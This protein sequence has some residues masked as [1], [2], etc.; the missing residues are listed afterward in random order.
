LN[1][2]LISPLGWF[3]PEHHQKAVDK[4]LL[5]QPADF[6]DGRR[7][8][9]VCAECGDLGCGALS[10]IVEKDGNRIVWRDFLYQNDYDPDI[11]YG[12]GDDYSNLGPFSFDVDQYAE[13]IGAAI[14]LNKNE[15]ATG[16]T[17]IIERLAQR[18]RDNLRK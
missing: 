8:I 13:A 10:A 5:E 7:S 17:S 12:G 6:P 15:P 18:M 2:D 1:L 16:D 3:L 11:Q 4:L 9:F 14:T